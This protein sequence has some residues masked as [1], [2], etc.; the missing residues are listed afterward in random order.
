LHQIQ[1]HQDTNFDPAMP[2]KK[3]QMLALTMVSNEHKVVLVIQW[4]ESNV[5]RETNKFP[6]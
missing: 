2:T 1:I 3:L 4:N 5:L 6:K